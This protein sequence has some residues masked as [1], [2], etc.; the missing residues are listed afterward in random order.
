MIRRLAI[1]LGLCGGLLASVAWSA[2]LNWDRN[3]EPDTKEYRVY[4]CKPGPTCTVVRDPVNRFGVVPQPAVGVIPSFLIPAAWTVGVA[5][6]TA[7][8]TSGNE[9]GLSVSVPFP[10]V[11]ADLTAPASPRNLRLQ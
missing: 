9:S 7:V 8:D 2:T 1:L 4:F 6:V 11:P 5:A 3:V 10:A